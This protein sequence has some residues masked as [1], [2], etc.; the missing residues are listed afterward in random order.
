MSDNRRRWRCKYTYTNRFGRPDH[1]YEVVGAKGGLHL[2]IT[3]YRGQASAG[4]EFSAGLELHSRTPL[5]EDVPPSFDE[6]WLLKCPCW[7]DGTT[8]CAEEYFLPL[9]KSLGNNHEA[10]FTHLRAEAD[11]RFYPEDTNHA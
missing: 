1:S 6:C 2:H 7:H 10:M 9:W 11:R 4:I 5:W 8:M 3:D